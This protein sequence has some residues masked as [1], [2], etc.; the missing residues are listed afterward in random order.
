MSSLLLKP[1][2]PAFTVS[3]PSEAM[4]V[5]QE[6]AC[7]LMVIVILSPII[8]Q[9]ILHFFLKNPCHKVSDGEITSSRL[10]I[11]RD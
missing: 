1:K 6:R 4:D 5:I 11:T 10:Y 2:I 9:Q 3:Q 8:K 7:E